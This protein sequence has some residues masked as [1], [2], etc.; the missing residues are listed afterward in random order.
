MLPPVCTSVTLSWSR[1]A[2]SGAPSPEPLSAM[3]TRGTAEVAWS[4][5]FKKVST[6]PPDQ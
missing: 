1:A 6:W 3:M 2:A 5:L 4:R